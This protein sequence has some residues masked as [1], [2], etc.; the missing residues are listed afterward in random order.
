MIL[1]DDMLSRYFSTKMVCWARSDE[2]GSKQSGTVINDKGV[3]ETGIDVQ[4]PPF[5]G[6]L[7]CAL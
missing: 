4:I 1:T 5:Q 3:G 2:R 6:S 7:E